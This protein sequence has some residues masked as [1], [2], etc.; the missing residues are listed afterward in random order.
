MPRRPH[1]RTHRRAK[2]DLRAKSWVY[3]RETAGCNVPRIR[4]ASSRKRSLTHTHSCRI[5]SALE[6]LMSTAKPS[7]ENSISSAFHKH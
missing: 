5:L 4:F 1:P 7:G 2:F 3:P 6:S